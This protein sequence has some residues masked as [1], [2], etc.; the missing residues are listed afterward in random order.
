MTWGA[1]DDLRHGWY[2]NLN[3]VC[4]ERCTFCA[5]ELADGSLRIDGRPAIVI[6]G[7]VERVAGR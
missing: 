2:L 3:Y 4:N 1:D 5:A 6:A 7:D